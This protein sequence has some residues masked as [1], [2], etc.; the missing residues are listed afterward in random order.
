MQTSFLE[1]GADSIVLLDAVRNVEKR[2]GLKLSIRQIFEELTT[3][4]T[5]AEHLDR[6]LPPEAVLAPSPSPKAEVIPAPTPASAPLPAT[7]AA[8][9]PAFAPS[10][11]ST[12][13]LLAAAQ[14]T[15][16]LSSQP[17]Q[18]P[19]QG[20]AVDHILQLQLQLMSQQLALLSGL[21]VEPAVV[22]D[23]V[24]APA[25]VAIGPP[26]APATSAPPAPAPTSVQ[27]SVQSPFSA[28]TLSGT[29]NKAL[30]PEQQSH[31]DGLITRYSRRTQRSK[32]NAIRYR[33][34]WSDVRW[35]MNFR[36]ELKE[37]CYPIV[38]VRS[39]GSRF[40]D[41]DNN[42]YIDISMG[43]GVHLFGHNPP[44][45]AE[46]LRKRLDEG[47]ELGPQSD[48]GGQ[49]AELICELTG[50]KR[51]TF[52]NSGTEAVMTALRLARAATKRTKVVMFTGSYHGH[53]DGT[54]IVGRMENGAPR[55]LPMAA[56]VSPRVAED[57]IVLP[58]GE[59]RS[60][61]II[62]EH[63]HELAAV[64]VEPVQSRRPNLQPKAF[65]QTLRLLTR[66]ASVPL[67]FDEMITGFRIH[68][69]GA[70]AWLGIEADMATYGKVVGG[71]MPIGV[72]ADRGGFVDRLDGGD[73]RYG[74]VS[75][76]SVETTFAAGTFC[77]HPLAMA[78][79]VAALTQMK[80][81]GPALQERLNQRTARLAERLNGIFQREQV[82]VMVVHCGS[83][84][85]FAVSGNF[86]YL[87]QPMEMDLLY[88]H[89]IERG[90]Y[91]WEGRT[92]MLS[93]AHTDADLDVI[94]RA[95]AESVAEIRAGGFWPRPNS[96]SPSPTP[97]NGT[98]EGSIALARTPAPST[99]GPLSRT[100]TAAQPQGFWERRC[101]AGRAAPEVGRYPARQIDFSLSYFGSY[102][103]RYNE[104]KYR[105]LFESAKLADQHGFMALWLPERHFHAFGGFSPN[106]SVLAAALARETQR[107][108]LRAG[109]V[110]LP[111][112]H[113]VRVAEEW[114]VVDNLSHGRVGI[115]FASGWHPNDFVFSPESYGK[116]RE[117]TFESLETVRSLWRGQS[118]RTKAGGGAEIQVELHPRP[119]QPEL[120]SWL[121]IVNNPETYVRAAE[122]GTSVLTNLMGQTVDELARNIALY[123]ETLASLGKDPDSGTVTV[124]IHT[125]VGPNLDE[126]RA[127]ARKP[128]VDYM[129]SSLS[130]FRGLLQSQG[131]QAN[132]ESMNEDDMDYLASA[133]FDRYVQSSAL[134]GTPES[135]APIVQ[136]LR[137]IGV[138]ELACFVDFGVPAEMVLSNLASLAALKTASTPA[139]A[140]ARTFSLTEAQQHLWVLSQMSHGGSIAYNL[141]MSVRMEGPL[142][143]ELLQQ[144]IRHVV[145]RHEALRIQ[146]EE[147]GER[148]SILS[149]REVPLQLVDLSAL[150]ATEQTARLGQWYLQENNA[151]FDLHRGPLFRT[152]LLKLGPQQH[153]L[154]LSAHHVVMDGWSLGIVLQEIAGLYSAALEG[155][156]LA[157]PAAMQL[158]DYVC[159]LE[160]Q[161]QTEE[162]AAHERYWLA[163]NVSELPVIDLPA[164]HARPAQRSF[165]GARET[166][167]LDATFSHVLRETA[168]QHQATLFMLLFSAYTTFLHRLTGQKDI[169][170]G[171]PTGGRD[172]EGSDRLV[173][174]CSHLL[175]IASHASG[176]HLFPEYFQALK[177]VFWGAF[178]HQAYPFARLLNRLKLPRTASRPPLINV[179]FNLERPLA[180]AKM[181]GLQTGFH[182]QP[183]AF[184]G[185]DLSL[186][187]IEVENGLA[188]DFDY[189]TDLFEPGT[190]AR[191]ARCFRTL[192]EGIV[193]NPRRPLATLPMLTEAERQQ[194]V[195]GWNQTRVP[196]SRERLIHQLIEQQAATRPSKIA[197]E[198]DGQSL[199]YADL[200]QQAN[201]L[202]HHLRAL[203]AGPGI[204][205]G[206]L[207]ERSL[208]MVVTLLAILK[209]GSAYVP[210]DPAHPRERM[211]FLLDDSRVAIVVTQAGLA[212]RLPAHAAKAVCLDR[213]AAAL[214]S[215]PVTDPENLATADA[216]AY[217]IYT[218]G[219]TGEPKGVVV[220]H[221]AFVVHCQDIQRHFGHTER[222]RMLQ[223][224]S[225]NFDASLEQVL[226]LFMIGAMVV[227]RGPQV[228]TPEEVPR[229]IAEQQLT[230]VNFPT[231]YWQQLTQRWSEAPPVVGANQLR[232]VIIG[233]DT[234]LP[235]VLELWQRGPLGSVRLLN[236]YGPTEAIITATTFEVPAPKDRPRSYTRVPIGRSLSNRTLYILDGYGNPVPIGVAGELHLGGEML[237][238]G[239]LHRP[240]L[241]AQRFIPDPFSDRRD[242]RLYKTGDVARFLP[243]GT[244]EFLGRT[245]HQ[246]KVRGFRIELGEIE[247]ALSRHP[248]VREGVVIVREEA[249]EALAGHDKRLVAYVVPTTAGSVTPDGLRR[250]LQEKLPDYMIPAFFVL[251]EAMPLTPSGK[252]DRRALPAPAPVASARSRPYVAPSTPTE[253]TLAELW[254]KTLRLQR[255]GIHDDFFVL[256]GDSLMATQVASRIRE[257]LQVELPLERL[258]KETTIS[259]LAE[260]LD[261][262]LW[263]AKPSAPAFAD[264]ARREEGEL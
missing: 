227:L 96:P 173:S 56:G 98:E 13:A 182:S 153:L 101:S 119:M 100:E 256:G 31:L 138:N 252:L 197:L 2:F 123:R 146:I 179:T 244:V 260:H 176:E 152:Y 206:A 198:C 70:Q 168:Q 10:S 178:E 97:G 42:E 164:D 45:I 154:V 136:R 85:R 11:A 21:T 171:I 22:T 195:L 143:A 200:N 236:A 233:G 34:K 255:V 204:L 220:E 134:I 237:A 194:L 262:L 19:V 131:M 121:T 88:A 172:L 219:S 8:S 187:V 95:V 162:F 79:T 48:L 94:V 105:L 169:L 117:I 202:A 55:S 249:N 49:A 38:S 68:P 77:K 36:A 62:R 58:Y 264:A 110:V 228:W 263:A 50:M 161:S 184:S 63:L 27:A 120:P 46:A 199:T 217:V 185:F 163:Q 247:S 1:M 207:F 222:D 223:F 127:Q 232:L 135:C 150:P 130:L 183:V 224:A 7:A 242:A 39:Q 104:D 253:Q 69:G 25:P 203:G 92:C 125:Y 170:V 186:N 229:R 193:A 4:D 155:K 67:I 81:E 51:V 33:A 191:W 3:L 103:A 218:S 57:M 160:Q 86:S 23:P 192:L 181:S 61:E 118:L 53:S 122:L 166:I 157:L 141:S 64:L 26:P 225:F 226:P 144:S 37:I 248:G 243:D 213:D 151:P 99:P 147:S 44:F 90:I 234:I 60:L 93:T 139:I 209:A 84:F 137:E 210:L 216:P 71:G 250:F 245:D 112:H 159:W 211:N 20:S 43:F 165:Q 14:A 240:E 246:V 156:A 29:P 59:E 47:M 201:R 80:K 129:K 82:P 65:L 76:P 89:L 257:A 109:S 174:Y 30:P 35:L 259:G 212:E 126:A 107:I 167:R 231:A 74:D 116:H 5:M 177:Q 41:A 221:G 75:Y 208:E 102:D 124:L 108:H 215:R 24:S 6:T 132:F 133:A 17:A 114:A 140:P 87:Y 180:V 258:F 235:K 12:Q 54:L 52:C 254:M 83:V 28:G 72:V 66:E 148:Q 196:Y 15:T 158:S 190:I 241:T 73:W 189:N 115:G 261:T 175:P 149:M 91:V 128:F 251:L 18:A 230:V 16:P 9:A 106:P 142:R 188:L 32:Q 205:V 238:R 145:E 78:T 214:A 40:W 111:L 113:P 239:Y